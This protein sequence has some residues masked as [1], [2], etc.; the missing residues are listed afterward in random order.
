MKN[1]PR[2]S[3]EGMVDIT[4][5]FRRLPLAR[6][7][8]VHNCWLAALR[9]VEGALWRSLQAAAS[10]LVSMSGRRDESRRRRHECPRHRASSS[11]LVGQLAHGHSLEDASRRTHCCVLGRDSARSARRRDES[12]R[13]RLKVRATLGQQAHGR[14][15]CGRGSVWRVTGCARQ[16][17]LCQRRTRR[18]RRLFQWLALPIL[19]SISNGI[20]SG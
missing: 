2:G 10:R 3:F 15:P 7:I 17:L 16:A 9:S 8:F 1:G 20:C 19:V 13:S 18:A 5:L 12:R 11:P 6:S 4:P 14:S